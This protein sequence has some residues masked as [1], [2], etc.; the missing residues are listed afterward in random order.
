MVAATM[1]PNKAANGAP[2]PEVEG[3]VVAVLM[4]RLRNLRKRLR[5]AEEIQA[6]LD[7]GKTLNQDQVRMA[8]RAQ[9]RLDPQPRHTP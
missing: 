5:N 9:A 2:A 4:K 6:K 1:A 8:W 3:P 7:A